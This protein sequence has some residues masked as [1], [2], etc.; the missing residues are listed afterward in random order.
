MKHNSLI[1]VF[2]LLV[3][4]SLFRKKYVFFS[5]LVNIYGIFPWLGKPALLWNVRSVYRNYKQNAVHSKSLTAN[6]IINVNFSSMMAGKNI[7]KTY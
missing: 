1:S 4:L 2:R 3:F 7:F 6:L 5:K